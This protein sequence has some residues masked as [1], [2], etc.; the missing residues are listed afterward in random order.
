MPPFLGAA[1]RLVLMRDGFYS[2]DARLHTRAAALLALDRGHSLGGVA[3]SVRCDR[4]T[5]YRWI[6]RYLEK[7]DVAAL[8]DGRTRDALRRARRL[9]P[10]RAA[11]LVELAKLGRPANEPGRLDLEPSAQEA[12]A[13]LASVAEPDPIRRYWAALL[14][15]YDRAL[16]ITDIARVAGC[17]RSTIYEA[18]ARHL[19]RLLGGGAGQGAA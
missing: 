16:P 11:A 15:A 12:L 1:E 8:C 9:K 7:R 19:P 18:P 4:D 13:R 17:H 5:L 10:A 3:R 14:L 2:P 6:D